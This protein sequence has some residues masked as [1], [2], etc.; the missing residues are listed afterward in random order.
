M[1]ASRTQHKIQISVLN[2]DCTL[3]P[4]NILIHLINCDFFTH[5]HE[6]RCFGS[7]AI[8]IRGALFIQSIEL[9]CA[10]TLCHDI[11][12]VDPKM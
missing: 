8:R 1:I 11:L 12:R 5:C 4:A 7:P 2:D 6:K 3:R 10:I 9:S